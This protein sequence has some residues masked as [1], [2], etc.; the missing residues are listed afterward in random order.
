AIQWHLLAL[1]D[2]DNC[3]N[4][5]PVKPR[6]SNHCC[7]WDTI[8]YSLVISSFLKSRPACSK[9]SVASDCGGR[10]IAH[11]KRCSGDCPLL[12]VPLVICHI[13]PSDPSQCA[14]VGAKRAPLQS[15]SRDT[16]TRA[17]NTYN[18]W[19]CGSNLRK[20][21]RLQRHVVPVDQNRPLRLLEIADHIGAHRRAIHNLVGGVP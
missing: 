8:G 18:L 17:H 9:V 10:P 11:N 21:L 6:P 16:G 15:P 12:A 7:Q 3:D 14:S 2:R 13:L 5:A 4:Q 1:A 20:R 19:K